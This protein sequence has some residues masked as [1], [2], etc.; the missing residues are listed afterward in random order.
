MANTV[1]IVVNIVFRHVFIDFF[2]GGPC[3]YVGSISCCIRIFIA[4]VVSIAVPVTVISV[5][6][7]A[8]VP[9][10]AI[11]AIVISSRWA[12]AFFIAPFSP[13]FG[14]EV[15]ELV[16]VETFDIFLVAFLSVCPE[17]IF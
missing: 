3:F 2:N 16:A 4:I 13:A 1:G 17:S 7:I 9:V 5:A 11:I 6:I 10:V 12:L 14:L 8:M 15:A